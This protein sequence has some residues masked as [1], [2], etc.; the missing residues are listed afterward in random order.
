MKLSSW[1]P[2]YYFPTG[3][4][5]CKLAFGARRV[6]CDACRVNFATFRLVRH[7]RHHATPIAHDVTVH[8]RVPSR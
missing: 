8:D 4:V 5:A 7:R 1:N 2:K 3:S 6:R